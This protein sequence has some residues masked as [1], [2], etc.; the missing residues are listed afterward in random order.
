M[1]K[2]EKG[3]DVY[4]RQAVEAACSMDE[5]SGLMNECVVI[6]SPHKDLIQTLV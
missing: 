4:K 6:P 3:S 5:V 2:A 1:K